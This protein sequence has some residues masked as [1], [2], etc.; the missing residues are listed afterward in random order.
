MS[1]SVLHICT[2]KHTVSHSNKLQHTATYCN[3]HCNTHCYKLQLHSRIE[4]MSCGVLQIR[5]QRTATH[6]NTL[7]HTATHCST[8][9]CTATNCNAL[10]HTA[11]RGNTL[12]HTLQRTPQHTA[13]VLT[14]EI[15]VLQERKTVF[16]RVGSNTLQYTATH[17]HTLQCIATHTATNTATHC[18]SIHT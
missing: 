17:Y 8:L 9:Q 6:C 18:S 14:Y 7:Q 10:Q 4:S 3:I 11:S 16:G 1:C 15:F 5:L 2:L 13:A 12:Q